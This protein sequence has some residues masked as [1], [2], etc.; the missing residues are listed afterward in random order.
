MRVTR[1]ELLFDGRSRLDGVGEL[2]PELCP[3]R[4]GERERLLLWP[5]DDRRPYC[6]MNGGEGG[7]K[8]MSMAIPYIGIPTAVIGDIGIPT[9]MAIGIPIPGMS[10][11]D[12][13]MFGAM[14]MFHMGGRGGTGTSLRR[15]E[16][17]VSDTTDVRRLALL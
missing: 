14:P 8:G 3:E 15:R 9:G 11:G 13:L 1:S 16:L 12:A 4:E 5:L 7:S 2:C 17:P 10:T 6:C